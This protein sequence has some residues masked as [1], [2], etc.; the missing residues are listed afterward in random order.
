MVSDLVTAIY[1]EPYEHIRALLEAGAD[2]NEAA[3]DGFPPL[4]AA[5]G[6][7]R[8]GPGMPSRTDVDDILR[9]LLKHGADPNQRGI[10]DW[11]ALHMAVAEHAISLVWILLSAGADPL[12]RTRIDDRET[13]RETAV[14]A[15]LTDIVSLFDQVSEKRRTRLRPGLMLLV[16]VPGAGEPVQ[17]QRDYRIRLQVRLHTGERIR[18][19][20]AWGSVD[21]ARLED[22]GD[23][24]ITKVRIDRRSLIPGLFYG[25]QGMRAGGTRVLEIAPHLAYGDKGVPGTIPPGAPLVAEIS[26]LG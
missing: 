7:V 22:G 21:A 12:L 19:K 13:A 8:A 3:P 10:N 14:A 17:R 25:I 23:T 24:L 5:I 11:T 18:W 16:D 2:P 9:L 1:R 20:T 26:V 15:N 4:I 6:C